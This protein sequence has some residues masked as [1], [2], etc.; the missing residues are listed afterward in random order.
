MLSNIS[1]KIKEIKWYIFTGILSAVILFFLLSIRSGLDITKESPYTELV[2]IFASLTAISV[3]LFFTWFLNFMSDVLFGGKS[4][5]TAFYCPEC[6]KTINPQHIPSDRN[7]R[8]PCP[9]CSQ[10]IT[11]EERIR[12]HDY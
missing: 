1:S 4:S 11:A 9:H 12:P 10:F 2:Q 3:I 5:H 6:R 8:F 7:K